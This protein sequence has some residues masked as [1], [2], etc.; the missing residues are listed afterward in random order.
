MDMTLD[1]IKQYLLDHA[2][3]G[4]PTLSLLGKG[5][6]NI[7]YLAEEGEHKLVIRIAR[8]D[9]PAYFRFE[10]ERHYML[11][12]EALNIEF[13]PRSIHYDPKHN[14]H[15]VSYVDGQDASVVDLN[16]IQT[17]VF[18]EQLKQLHNI[19]YDEYTNWC[20]KVGQAPRGLLTL[21]NRNKMYLQGKLQDIHNHL[22][23]NP[24]ANNVIEWAEPKVKILQDSVNGIELRTVFLHDDLR[25]NENGGNLKL[26]GDQVIFID[27]ELSGFF[28]HLV[29]EIGDVLGSIPNFNNSV[30]KKL[31]KVYVDGEPNR[32]QLDRSIKYGVLWGRLGNT[33]WAAERYLS[34]DKA[35]H[36]DAMR[37]RQLT[38]QGMRDAEPF[39]N[40]PFNE[41]FD[42]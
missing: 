17:E 25:W 30:M 13:A 27:W 28:D 4:N 34:L 42:K 23:I 38:K 37:Y 40:R 11:F 1:E 18:V 6:A 2:L 31:Y 35:N 29:P 16:E 8:S 12:I 19:S 15:I 32:D 22:K 9:V 7:N 21:E 33:L 36:P 39:F 24:F 41:W 20:N 10:A 26:K 3:L 14:I 5:E